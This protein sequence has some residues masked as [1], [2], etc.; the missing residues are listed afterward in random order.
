MRQVS[1]SIYGVLRKQ[2]PTDGLSPPRHKRTKGNRII[3]HTVGSGVSSFCIMN[4]R[5]LREWHEAARVH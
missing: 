1:R 2:Q 5:T 4:I 3:L